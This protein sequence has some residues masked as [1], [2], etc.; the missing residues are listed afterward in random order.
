MQLAVREHVAADERRARAAARVCDARDAVVEEQP[1]RPQQPAHR[2]DVGVELRAADVL[3]HADARDL[4]ERLLVEL[5]VVEHAH[6]DAVGQPGLRD[7]PARELRLR[8]RQR[9]AERSHAVVRRR[10]QDERA[11]AA[12]DVEQP[13]A[14]AQAQLAADQLELALLRGLERI[15]ARSRS[16][17]RSRPGSARAATRRSGSRRR[18]DG[19][20]T[21]GR[22]AASAA[23]RPARPRS[24]GSAAGAARAARPRAAP[25]PRAARG[26]SG[27]ARGRRTRWRRSSTRSRS[28]SASSAPDTHARLEPELVGRAQEMRDRPLVADAARPGRRDR[29]RRPRCRPRSAPS[30]AAARARSREPSC[31]R[32][33][34]PR[35][36]ARSL[37]RPSGRSSVA[38]SSTTPLARRCASCGL[39]TAPVR[40]LGKGNGAGR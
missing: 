8:L 15:A 12:A 13:L 26:R 24:A 3:V 35:S 2:V 10:V 7:A 17:R 4:V 1:A 23:A 22:G 5:A 31:G 30:R 9:H 33:A 14:R 36:V 38:A 25:R 37:S 19:A 28:P 18:S 20:P 11:P 39:T 34:R 29:A 6:L 16:R 40:G 32:P 21:R 27:R